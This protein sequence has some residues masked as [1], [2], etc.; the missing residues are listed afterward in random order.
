MVETAYVTSWFCTKAP[1]LLRR[2]LI[3][4]DQLVELKWIELARVE[5][6]EPV[7]DMLEEQ[8]QLLL[9]L[10]A[11]HLPGGPA[12]GFLAFDVPDT[13]AGHHARNLP[14]WAVNCPLDAV[15]TTATR[16]TKTERTEPRANPVAR[17]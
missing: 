4:V 8:P 6:V 10:F 3:A 13:S 7:T 17:R 16:A 9:V 11:D 15:P 2:A 1:Q 5:L 14:R 12:P